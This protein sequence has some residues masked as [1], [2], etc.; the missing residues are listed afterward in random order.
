NIRIVDKRSGRVLQGGGWNPHPSGGHCRRRK[1]FSEHYRGS[2]TGDVFANPAITLYGYL[3]RSA[4]EPQPAATGGSHADQTAR[5][6]RRAAHV[7]PNMEPSNGR[8]P[9]SLAYGGVVARCSWCD[10]RDV[11]RDRYIWIGCV[12]GQQAPAGFGNSYGPRSTAQGS[13]AGCA[14]RRIKIA[15][16]WF[17][18]RTGLGNFRQPRARLHRV[19]SNCTR[20]AGL[21]LHGSSDVAARVGSNVDSSAARSVDRSCRPPPSGVKSAFSLSLIQ[22]RRERMTPGFSSCSSS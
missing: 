11:V 10:G 2:T 4:L 13:V 9:V 12:F 19:S 14:G 21:S 18:S 3:A 6:R 5:P 17:G 7:H 8:S 1:I 22:R 15:G 20:P 16:F